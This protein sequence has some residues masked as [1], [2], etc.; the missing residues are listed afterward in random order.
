M[1]VDARQC[2]FAVTNGHFVYEI[3]LS[4]TKQRCHWNPPAVSNSPTNFATAANFSRKMKSIGIPDCTRT[5]SAIPPSYLYFI[6]ELAN[7]S[8]LVQRFIRNMASI[9]GALIEVTV[10]EDVSR[11]YAFSWNTQGEI[12]VETRA[13]E[14]A[15]HET[16]SNLKP[17]SL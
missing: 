7:A 5:T 1:R 2:V 12:N 14:G 13:D 9:E 8:C 10:V 3:R 6:D 4:D 15:E 16:P 17:V 11:N